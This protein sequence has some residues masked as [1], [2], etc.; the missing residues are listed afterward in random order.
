MVVSAFLQSGTRFTGTVVSTIDAKP[1]YNAASGEVRWEIGNLAA[2]KGVIGQPLEAVFQ[3][4]NTPAVNQ[5]G[6][7]IPLLGETR[8][9]AND[10][11]VNAAL[12]NSA[13][14]V[15]S[16]VRDDP[17]ITTSDRKVQP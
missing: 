3:I 6:Q 14:S 17:T 9:Q 16:D 10:M 5:V 8:I 15:L 7:T 2:T 11:F 4:E 12:V 1:V 13:P